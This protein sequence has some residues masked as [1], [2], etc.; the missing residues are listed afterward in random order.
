MQRR[1]FLRILA[2]AAAAATAGP[3]LA[4][5]S[6]DPSDGGSGKEPG[7]KLDTLRIAA[8]G[9]PGEGLSPAEAMSTATWAVLYA[10][11]ESLVIADDDGAL[12][13][14]A[15]KAEPND[16]ATV[17]TVSLRDGA[18][19]SDGSPVTAEDVLASF[20]ETAKDPMKGM[21]L[22]DIDLEASAAKD[23]STVE[24]T[25]SR[26]RADFVGTVLGLSSLVFKGGDPSNGIG[27]GPYVVDSGD[28]GQGWKL[29]ANPEYPAE[30]R[31]S[32]N[33]EVQ[34]I[35]D[36]DARS[37]AVDSGAVDLA[38][39]L[40]A[41]ARRSLRTAEA[42][43]P[44]TADSKGLM[45]ILNTTVAPFDDPD[46]RRAAKIALDR[47][48]LVDQALD[49]AGE[50][51]A[52]IP[53]LGFPGYPE[54]I[55]APK[56]DVEEARRIFEEKGVKEFTIVTADFSPGMNDGAELA[57]RQFEEAGVKVTVDKRDPTTYF[58]DMGALK[59]LPVFASYFVNR[60][61]ESG[62]PFLTGSKAMFNLSGF[63]SNPEWDGKLA[64]AQA[65]TDDGR[66]AD[67]IADLAEEMHEDG[68]ELLWG[69]ANA[70]HGRA[71]GVPDMPVSL[72]V[73]LPEKK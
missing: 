2:T 26:P 69:Y 25:L 67:M 11:Y 63:G 59:K 13:Q 1:T 68:G 66:R 38:V 32:D 30:K 45:F 53:G 47:P 48:A 61:L 39:D 9:A 51:G 70:V 22:A 44:G 15:E 3:V 17:W 50:P 43:V 49:G 19:F 33:L 5:C 73:P 20:R 46:V 54:K 4:A 36:A 57:A 10:V 29:T 64:A 18:K 31:I 23:D 14:L 42:W 34:V 8:I 41:T 52:D 7:K 60:P 24:F 21:T 6:S 28:S 62:L 55:K 27:S 72:S 16:D 58:A 35:A 65:E 56:R 40:P 37:R 12:F 71:E